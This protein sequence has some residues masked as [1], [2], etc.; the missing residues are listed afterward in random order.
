MKKE[1][2][3]AIRRK[4]QVMVRNTSGQTVTGFPERTADSSILSLRTV[5]GNVWIPFDEVEQVTRLLTLRSHHLGTM[6]LV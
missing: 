6:Q 5:Q 2:E 1:V 3:I 4:Q